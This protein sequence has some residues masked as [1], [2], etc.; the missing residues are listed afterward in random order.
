MSVQF[1][2]IPGPLAN[3]GTTENGFKGEV[4]VVSVADFQLVTHANEVQAQEIHSLRA[5]IVDLIAEVARLQRLIQMASDTGDLYERKLDAHETAIGS[6]R[7]RLAEAGALLREAREW[8]IPLNSI[9]DKRYLAP[10]I[11]AFLAG[12]SRPASTAPAD[13]T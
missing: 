12:V 9:N 11:D 6:L 1:Y 3:Y 4:R 7:S 5:D 10:R 13:S 2:W 8:F